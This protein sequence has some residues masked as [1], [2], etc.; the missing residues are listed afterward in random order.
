MLGIA[1]NL[2]ANETSSCTDPG[3]TS[4]E[5]PGEQELRLGEQ[6]VQHP[7]RNRHNAPRIQLPQRHH[8]QSC[9]Q[10]QGREREEGAE[11]LGET[12]GA[13]SELH[14]SEDWQVGTT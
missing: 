11:E 2:S 8:R 14:S 3:E 13:V 6:R 4:F 9:V 12:E 5:F 10:E 7:L 1:A